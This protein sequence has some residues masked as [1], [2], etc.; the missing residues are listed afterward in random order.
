MVS[1]KNV[2]VA[3]FNQKINFAAKQGQSWVKDPI[4]V[5]RKYNNWLG[6]SMLIF[7]NGD[8]ERPSKY[9]ITIISEGFLD[10]SLRG[11]RDEIIVAR[12]Q[13]NI[14]HLKSVKT[15]W[16]CWSRRGHTDYSIKP[17]H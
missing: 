14:W 7:I 8:G 6:R 16:R 3:K 4:A 11:Q 2:D 13:L 15:S 12:D 10:D 17:C 9:K 5:I 1:S